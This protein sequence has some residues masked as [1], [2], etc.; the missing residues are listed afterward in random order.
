MKGQQEELQADVRGISTA[1]GGLD[2]TMETIGK[3]CV[4]RT[5]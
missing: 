2:D 4:T 1:V 5:D 3:I